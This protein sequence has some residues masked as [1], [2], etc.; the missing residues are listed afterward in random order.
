[1]IK[2]ERFKEVYEVPVVTTWAKIREL[3]EQA[4]ARVLERIN[5][6]K[7]LHAD[8][9]ILSTQHDHYE[10]NNTDNSPFWDCIEVMYEE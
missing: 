10:S 9:V 8:A 7:V 3:R 6:W 2:L 5:A 4:M 1:M